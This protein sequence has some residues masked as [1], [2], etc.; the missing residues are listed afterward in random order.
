MGCPSLPAAPTRWSLTLSLWPAPVS[1]LEGRTGQLMASAR[2][3]SW[4]RPAGHARRDA[5]ISLVGALTG[6]VRIGCDIPA[7]QITGACRPCPRAQRRASH[8]HR[9]TC[10]AVAPPGV[11]QCA[12]GCT[13][14]HRRRLPQ[15]GETLPTQPHVRFF[16]LPTAVS[17]P[18][19]IIG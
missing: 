19:L 8:T 12:Q 18:P 13:E 16:V 15:A 11:H 3:P 6:D 7:Y 5:V 9:H 10:A 14:A 2:V 4:P 1:G 17:S